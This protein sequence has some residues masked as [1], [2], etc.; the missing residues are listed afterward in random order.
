VSLPSSPTEAGSPA[1]RLPG[2]PEAEPTTPAA[3]S[4]L[5]SLVREIIETVILTV[6]IY[7]VV[8]FATSRFRVEGDSMQPTMHPD[9][10]VLIDKVSYMLG[11]PQRGDIVVF[12]YPFG[13]E[14][15]FIKRIIGL[16]GETV[17]VAAGVVSVDGRPLDEPYIAA[18]PQYQG[19]WTLG[20]DEYFVLGDNRNNSLD[21]HSWGPLKSDYLI[22]RALV[23]YWPMEALQVVPHFDYVTASAP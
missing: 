14:R 3:P 1:E 17:S 22:G 13:T 9:E 15:D 12:Q 5:R 10:Y 4:R 21:S 16:P 19:A 18:P 8:N 7:A 20:A 11:A 2:P 6:V 23:V